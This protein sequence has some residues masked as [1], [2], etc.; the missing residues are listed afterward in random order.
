M[1]AVFGFV[2]LLSFFVLLGIVFG[3]PFDLAKTITAAVVLGLLALFSP[4]LAK[5]CAAED[6]MWAALRR[7][8]WRF[9]N[10]IAK[11]S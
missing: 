7:R 9:A 5:W 6:R 10:R 2:I 11:P 1:R 8:L 3:E 4:T